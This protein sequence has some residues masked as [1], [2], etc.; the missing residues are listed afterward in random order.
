[1]A[2]GVER[3]TISKILKER[4]RY[5]RMDVHPDVDDHS[6]KHRCVYRYQSGVAHIRRPSKFPEIESK[7]L[8]HLATWSGE[9]RAITDALIKSTALEVAKEFNIALDKFKG[10]SGWVENFKNRNNIKRGEW[11]ASPTHRQNQ[12]HHHETIPAYDQFPP[13]NDWRDMDPALGHPG[14]MEYADQHTRA[15]TLQE[16][17]TALDLVLAYLEMRDRDM[18]L[19]QVPERQFLRLMK[20]LF[21]QVSTGSPVDRSKIII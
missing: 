15:P 7:M 1:M 2:F 10:S 17:Q 8:E 3:S 21:Y 19:V 9:A 11:L 14:S 13:Y 20:G 4:D 16:A 12:Q 18:R 6:A 5:L